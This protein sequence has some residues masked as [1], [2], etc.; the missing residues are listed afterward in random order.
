MSK[1][2]AIVD[3]ETTGFLPRGLIVEVGISELDLDTG[4]VK[5]IYNELVKEPGF[6]EEDH[7]VSWIFTNT[8][9]KFEDVMKADPLDVKTIQV[10]LDKYPT[11]AYN[12]KF[13]FGFFKLR[14]LKVNE[15]PCP[16]IISTNLCKLEK[17]RG[18]GYKWPKV[19]EV[20][21]FLFPDSGYIETHRGGDDSVHEAKIVYELYKRALFV[22]D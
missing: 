3:I 22:V 21:D 7:M 6:C 12:K 18:S 2:I 8:D 5:L 17:K 15:L 13:D 9:L 19:Q 4:E 10:I 14:G 11:T 20:W 1:K 16:M